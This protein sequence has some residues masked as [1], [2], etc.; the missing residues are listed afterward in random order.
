MALPTLLD[1]AKQNGS[2][3]VAGLI[4][5]SYQQTPEVSGAV[6]GPGGS[7]V[8]VPNVGAAR[9]IKGRQ[10]KTLVRT[11]YPAIN[12]RGANEG[13]V[14]SVSAYENRLV[15]TYILNP[16][17]ECDKAVA[18]SHEDGAETYIAREA[19]AQVEAAMR[20]LGKQFYYGTGTGGDSKG[21]P[22]LLGSVSSALT[23][24]AG[25]TTANTGSSV[26]AVKWGEQHVIWVY[27]ENGSLEMPTLRVGDVF[28]A[29]NNRFTAYIQDLFAYPGLQVGSTVSVG[30]IRKLTE[31]AGKGLTDNLIYDLLSK[32]PTGVV[33][34][35]LLMSRRS[36]RQ[37]R[38][39]RTATNQ[40]G[41]PA[42]LP[43]EVEG[44]PIAIT[45]SILDTESL[46]L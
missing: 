4:E 31:D 24:D 44:I 34:D 5:E 18:D 14:P 21:H 13:V 11:G 7:M 46:T 36:L 9:T 32:F 45:E 2:D 26:W 27:G 40:T 33:P 16:R 1:I 17:W 25:G 8:A 42:P 41:A 43:A 37:L 12:F 23:V 3:A 29:S 15:E 38:Q 30:R 20:L 19:Q 22:G 10:Y 39:S 35:V 6:R 28:D